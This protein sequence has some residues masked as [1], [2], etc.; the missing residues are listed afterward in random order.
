[1]PRAQRVSLAIIAC[2]LCDPWAGAR[3]GPVF[4]LEQMVESTDLIVVGRITGV[5]SGGIATVLDGTD[6]VPA[7]RFFANLRVYRVLKG[8]LSEGPAT[9]RYDLPDQ[10]I[11]WATP[12]PDAGQVFFLKREGSVYIV[13][14]PFFPSLSARRDGAVTGATALD[15]VIHECAEI[16]R[17]P[18]SPPVTRKAMLSRL[19]GA[20]TTEAAEALQSA[21][22]ES[23]MEIHLHAIGLLAYRGDGDAWNEALRALSH[24]PEGVAPDTVR[25]LARIVGN[26]AP[27]RGGVDELAALAQ[28][29]VPRARRNLLSA[30]VETRASA[31][32]PVLTKALDDPDPDVRYTAVAGLAAVT[33]QWALR[34]SP[35]DFHRDEA[36]HLARW[37]Q[38]SAT[39][40]P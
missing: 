1:M 21:A 17:D 3:P 9:L 23:N 13:A 2:L 5:R 6:H 36:T 8:T 33:G 11:G 32:I 29:A 30:L 15:R 24:P 16:V 26:T 37:K 25:N 31:A 27:S 38:W 14:N 22:R 40:Q 7:R 34:P 4:T 28:S 12:T 18:A 20:K 10:F 19:A 35:E 39:H